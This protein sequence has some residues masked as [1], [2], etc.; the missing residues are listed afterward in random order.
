MTDTPQAGYKDVVV[1]LR[2]HIETTSVDAS[3][4]IL[5]SFQEE[6]NSAKRTPFYLL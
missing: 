5:E 6:L 1:R 3:L 2:Q 4:D